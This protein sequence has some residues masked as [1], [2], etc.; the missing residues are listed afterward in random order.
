[1]TEAWITLISYGVF[2]FHSYLQ[3]RKWFKD[4][5]EQDDDDEDE[6]LLDLAVQKEDSDSL[7]P[8]V[9][10]SPPLADAVK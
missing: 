1:M 6:E 9:S 8:L 7:L 4:K 2:I 3:D 5:D 10:H